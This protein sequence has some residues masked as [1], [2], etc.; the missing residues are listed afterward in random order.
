MNYEETLH[1]L[2]KRIHFARVNMDM[3]QVDF[4][5][6]AAISPLTLSRAERGLPI[7]TNTLLRILSQIPEA[8]SVLELLLPAVV[9]SPIAMQKL[10]SEQPLRVRKKQKP[11]KKFRPK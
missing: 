3:R 10:K 1:E 4:A 2:G 8:G 5:R 11:L 6:R 7:A 9:I